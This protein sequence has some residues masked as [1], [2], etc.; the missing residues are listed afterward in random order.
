[1]PPWWWQAEALADDVQVALDQANEARRRQPGWEL[2]KCKDYFG[3]LNRLRTT[4]FTLP[5]FDES[6]LPPEKRSKEAKRFTKL[7]KMIQ[8]AEQAA[9]LERPSVGA[10]ATFEPSILDHSAEGMTQ[11]L[12]DITPDVRERAGQAHDEF[13]RGWTRWHDTGARTNEVL[14][15]LS[16]SLLDVRNNLSHGEKTRGGPDG[17]RAERNRAVSTTV[18]PVLEDILDFIL[19]RPSQKLVAY[20][21]LRPGQPNHHV[22]DVDGTWLPVTLPGV[23]DEE[24]EL[25][26]FTHAQYTSAEAELFE[27][28]G[29]PGRWQHLDKFEGSRYER[30]LG[31]YRHSGLVGVANVYMKRLDDG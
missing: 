17:E 11:L 10:F 14:G 15:R 21:T 23:I 30:L 28:P 29:L 8:P 22:L 9:L 26:A 5:S 7:L 4:L 31:L 27:S 24:A 13:K 25:P 18:L 3:A 19:D 1:M 12:A 20:G 16:R 2:D 6:S